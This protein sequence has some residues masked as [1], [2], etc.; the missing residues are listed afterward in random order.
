MTHKGFFEERLSFLSRYS[1]FL[2]IRTRLFGDADISLSIR[3]ALLTN[4]TKS[5]ANLSR[6]ACPKN[7]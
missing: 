2:R 6:F 4:I 5:T 1:R 3:R 7:D